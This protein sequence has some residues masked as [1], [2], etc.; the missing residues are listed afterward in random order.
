MRC[1]CIKCHYNEDY[2]CRQ[3]DYVSIDEKGECDQMYI[4]ATPQNTQ[5]TQTE[6]EDED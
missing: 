2:C 4:P 1:K 3:P 5:T 6:E